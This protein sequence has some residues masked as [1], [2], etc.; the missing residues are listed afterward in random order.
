M[1][2]ALALLLG[3]LLFA[4]AAS[5]QTNWPSFRGGALGNVGESKNLPDTWDTTK[6]V[7]WKAD[8]PG[9]GWS[10]PVIWGDRVFLT[11]VVKEGEFPAARKGL[12]FG[13]EQSKPSPDEHR[14]TVL[15][16]DFKTG[17]V[18]WE[19]V[20]HKGKPE[21]TVHVKNTYASETPVCDGERLYAYFGNV[22]VFCY[23]HDGKELWSQR[24]SPAKTRLGW[25]TAASPVLHKDRLFVVNDNEEKSY[26]VALDAK[27]GSELWKVERDEKSNW[28]TPFVWENEKR[29]ELVTC[30]T[31]AVRS[32]DLDGKLLWELGGMS[33][34]VIPTPSAAHGLLYVSS[35]YVLDGKRPLFAIK[36]GAT[37]D[38]S[39]KP[40]QDKND[41]VAWCQKQAGPYN[42][43]PLILGDQVYVLYD[44]GMLSSYDAKTGEGAYNRERL[45]GPFTVSPWGYDG[46]VFCLNEDGDCFVIKAGP[47]FERLRTN[48][49]GEMC[50]ASPAIARDS[51]FIRTMTKLYRIENAR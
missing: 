6:N 1:S 49:L 15:C 27:S 25:G 14:W 35:G 23:D 36:P 8:V 39:L 43:S 37:G 47:K 31:K 12:Y 44:L 34:I 30:G 19:K 11:T 5:A 46:K 42:T 32:Y 17:K 29:T 40:D 50:M 2:R 38:I 26:L 4:P 33:S 21:T 22:G 41:F 28:A 16:L 48:S 18:L 10:S 7:V 3:L 13:G 24:F 20:A 51:L 45:E 9:R